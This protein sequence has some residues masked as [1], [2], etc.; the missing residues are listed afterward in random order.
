MPARRIAPLFLAAVALL[1][2]LAT[3]RLARACDCADFQLV[4]PADGAEDVP[5]DTKLWELGRHATRAPTHKL[6]GPDAEV[7]LTSVTLPGPA[8]WGAVSSP[9]TELM[10]GVHYR[11]VS[12]PR[13]RPCTT[14]STF[15]VGSKRAEKPALPAELGRTSIFQKEG[16]D[17][18]CGPTDTRLVSFD[19][20]WRGLIL[21]VNVDGTNGYPADVS[22]AFDGAFTRNEKILLGTSPCPRAW[23]PDG[24]A[25]S[26]VSFG[27]VSLA[28]EFSG[29]TTPTQVTLPDDD[30]GGCALGRNSV[31]TG[32][33]W[34]LG[35]A[36]VLGLLFLR[37]RRPRAR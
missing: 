33:P 22:R 13:N 34:R 9:A 18:S 17:S 3:A 15:R 37:R 36:A 24:K 4:A 23:A 16:P 20:H 28:G 6:I 27:A 10:P 7:P 26:D 31:A 19:M 14:L 5:P 30:S 12:C 25:S 32:A 1:V 2:S 21:L 29:W 8:Q 35:I 11:F